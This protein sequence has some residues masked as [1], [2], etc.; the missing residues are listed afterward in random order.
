MVM[1]MPEMTLF[2]WNLLLL[3]KYVSKI[4][5]ACKL[6]LTI[7]GREKGGCAYIRE[8]GIL[9]SSSTKTSGIVIVFLGKTKA[10]TGTAGTDFP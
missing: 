4:C 1:L 6:A 3:V 9:K 10:L 2:I 5:V 8:G 7:E